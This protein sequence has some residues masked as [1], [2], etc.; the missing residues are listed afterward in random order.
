MTTLSY[1]RDIRSPGRSIH[2]FY[3]FILAL[4]LILMQ[5][6]VTV[7][8]G[9]ARA[10]D[11]GNGL[12]ADKIID[13]TPEE[14]CEGENSLPRAVAFNSDIYLFWIHK[15]PGKDKTS[16]VYYRTVDKT[17]ERGVVRRLYS[18]TE[19]NERD[20]CAVG[21]HD[22]L[23]V[24][25]I[26][27]DPYATTGGDWD[28]MF[29]SYDPD[30]GWTDA[31]EASPHGD[32]RDDYEPQ[33]IVID[34]TVFLFWQA[35]GNETRSDICLRT[36]KDGEFSNV[37]VITD[38]W[39][40]SSISPRAAYDGHYIYV[41]WSTSDPD[42][43][44]GSDYDVIMMKYDPLSMAPVQYMDLGLEGD[45][46][47]DLSPSIYAHGG[48]I[49]VAWSS[50]DKTTTSGS[51]RDILYGTYDGVWH[52]PYEATNAGDSGDD[53][54]PQLFPYNDKM[55]M[56]WESSD[57][58]I[59]SGEDW[60][61]VVAPLTTGISPQSAVEVS[62]QKDGDDDGNPYFRG[63]TVVDFNSALYVFWELENA[64]L[65]GNHWHHI[66]LRIL[67]E[68]AGGDGGGGGGGDSGSKDGSGGG[69]SGGGA[70]ESGDETG[71]DAGAI[72]GLDLATVIALFTTVA[73]VIAIIAVFIIRRR[74]RK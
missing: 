68:E 57:P 14:E 74:F 28:V 69:G 36:Y 4:I 56:A 21:S 58:T 39:I 64:E 1:H 17:G 25:W 67:T 8:A 40:G 47:D 52:G 30:S 46:G 15:D 45:T 63:F 16:D 6:N 71:Y 11:N 9:D 33:I 3:G 42:H 60:D 32:I 34:S 18:T 54:Y 70:G 37:T 10:K 29:T 48:S 73:V 20:V 38:G 50:R 24:A 12:V 62:P 5:T 19:G 49:Y 13:L 27:D 65:F 51:D 31:V 2:I 55:Y 44:D 26:S 66:G 7:R 61:I 41:V 43:T 22:R 72:L 35:G 53:N 23:Y 59:T